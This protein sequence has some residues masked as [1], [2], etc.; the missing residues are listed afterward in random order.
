MDTTAQLITTLSVKL[1]ARSSHSVIVPAGIEALR[2]TIVESERGTDASNVLSIT[3]HGEELESFCLSRIPGGPGTRM[4][5]VLRSVNEIILEAAA[6]CTLLLTYYRLQGLEPFVADYHASITF[7]PETPTRENNTPWYT[8]GKETHYLMQLTKY[9]KNFHQDFGLSFTGSGSV[10]GTYF[11]GTIFLLA[12]LPIGV[13][14]GAVTIITRDVL[15]GRIFGRRIQPDAEGISGDSG[16]IP[17]FNVVNL[18]NDN[19]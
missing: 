15:I 3:Q 6:D 8:Y 5:P 13:A 10:E 17:V 11:A 1:P 2:V 4:L 9:E 14:K 18:A 12:Q 19:V 7:S 16:G